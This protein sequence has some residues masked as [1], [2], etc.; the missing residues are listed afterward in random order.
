VQQAA[1]LQR[2]RRH[3]RA[4]VAGIAKG[5]GGVQGGIA[6]L[7]ARP[8]SADPCRGPSRRD[9]MLERSSPIARGPP[10]PEGQVPESY[11]KEMARRTR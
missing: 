2:H 1:A 4:R 6:V 10:E 8:Q 5:S 7:E 11:L 3:A 9:V